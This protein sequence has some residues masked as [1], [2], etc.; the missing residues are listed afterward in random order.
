MKKLHLTLT[1][2]VLC[3]FAL[4]SLFS[5][6]GCDKDAGNTAPASRINA[7]NAAKI[8]PGMDR[9]QVEALLG[10][11]T[12]SETKDMV[13]FKKTTATY[14]AGKQS[15]EVIY[16]NSQVEEV[17]STFGNSAGS[18]GDTTSSTTTTTTTTH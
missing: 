2:L 17:H 14:V 5:L 4:F 9:E 16:K 11:P 7:A 12:T 6:A 10:P 18:P 13:I 3:A 8:Q 15:I 1:C